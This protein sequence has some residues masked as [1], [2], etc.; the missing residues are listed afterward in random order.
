VFQ[1]RVNGATA[2]GMR[3]GVFWAVFMGAV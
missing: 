1:L 3:C 2:G